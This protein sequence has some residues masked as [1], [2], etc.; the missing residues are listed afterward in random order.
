LQAQP[1]GLLVENVVG[2]DGS[3][4]QAQLAAALAACG[5]HTQVC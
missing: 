1:K 4:V 2:F 5:Y 3:D